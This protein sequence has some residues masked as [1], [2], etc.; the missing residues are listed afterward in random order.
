MYDEE[1]IKQLL[2]RGTELLDGFMESMIW[3]SNQRE[4][5]INKLREDHHAGKISW[6]HFE[7]MMEAVIEEEKLV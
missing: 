6:E 5:I 4:A 7:E 2:A 3:A 1:Q